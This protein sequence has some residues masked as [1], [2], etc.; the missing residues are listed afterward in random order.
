MNK[1]ISLITVT[2]KS[3][4]K[5]S[6]YI[7][8]FLKYHPSDQETI[9]FIF[10]ENSSSKNIEKLILPL[11]EAGFSVKL[12]YTENKGFGAGCNSGAKIAS[13][14][15][16]IF[17]NPDLIF[18]SNISNIG[19]NFLN[20]WGTIRQVNEKN[21]SYSMDLLPE[22]KNFFTEVLCLYKY[23]D[24]SSKYWLNKSYV[25]GS[26]FICDKNL[27]NKSTGFDERFFLYYEE[28]ELSSR[29]H[30]ISGPPMLDMNYSILHIGLGSHSST[31]AAIKNEING[32]KTYCEITN[33]KHLLLKIKNYSAIKGL[34]SKNNK[35]R[36][37]LIG[38]DIK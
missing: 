1:K 20:K 38:R 25:V 16:L 35:I 10:I 13:N 12:N 23:I 36:S 37:E 19:C 30:K 2:H 7:S 9:E 29:L 5:I 33:Q 28:A 3:E 4:N 11:R 21:K 18:L 15:V 32:L 24:F 26:F 27:F 6:A 22:N 31:T 14:D 34:L 17:A 8:S